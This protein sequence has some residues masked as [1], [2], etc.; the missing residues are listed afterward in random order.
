M[1]ENTRIQAKR[2]MTFKKHLENKHQIAHQLAQ[3]K[4][5]ARAEKIRYV[6][7][8]ARECGV[9]EGNKQLWYAVHKITKDDDSMEFFIGTSTPT[10][11]LGFI[12]YF[13]GVNN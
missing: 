11:R 6:Q 5:V 9:D 1:S 2:N 7:Q 12:E 4:E 13:V 8:L 3:Q 10:R